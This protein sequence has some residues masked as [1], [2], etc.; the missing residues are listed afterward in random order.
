[1]DT[2]KY[3][4][5]RLARIYDGF[6]APGVEIT[7]G[8]TWLD[9]SVVPVTNVTVT[10]DAGNA[11]GGATVSIRGMYNEALSEWSDALLDSVRIG[12]KLQISLG[13]TSKKQVFY[14]FIDDFTVSYTPEESAAVSITGIDAKAFL[15]NAAETKYYE[16]TTP[17]DIINEMLQGCMGS[18]FA[19]KI[20]LA[21][22]TDFTDLGAQIV[23]KSEND[24]RVLCSLAEV[25]NMNFFVVNGE[26]IFQKVVDKTTPIITLELGTSLLSF[27]RTV[28]LHKQ[29]GEIVV[30]S[31]S[32]IGDKAIEG[33]AKS[34]SLGSGKSAGAFVSSLNKK[35]REITSDFVTT[36]KECKALAQ[37]L[38]DRQAMDFVSGSGR[39]TGLPELIPGRY[40][41]L[42]GMDE[43]SNASYFISKVK[44]TVSADGGYY[45]DFDVN[46]AKIG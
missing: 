17:Y 31:H 10:I 27:T 45:T 25:N 16:N 41:K 46:G 29:V 28:S 11:A 6:M 18:G 36:P 5:E 34:T 9:T 19:T 21:K 4:F 14:G 37:N 33:S 43:E 15:M 42:T 35:V 12:A 30:R 40:I 2:S 32:K 23:Q 24:Y 8:G 20:S 22:A 1:M 13:Y 38:F 44:H 3:E 26:L 39:C 7:V